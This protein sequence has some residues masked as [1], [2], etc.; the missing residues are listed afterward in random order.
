[1]FKVSPN[2]LL[3]EIPEMEANTKLSTSH[4]LV[5]IPHRFSQI[6]SRHIKQPVGGR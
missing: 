3:T 4:R 2:F 1:M 5:P 6:C